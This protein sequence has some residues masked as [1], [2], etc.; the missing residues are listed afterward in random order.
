MRILA[1]KEVESP[2]NF[3]LALP[4]PAVYTFG[5]I[6]HHISG[7]KGQK[8]QTMIY[9]TRP[10]RWTLAITTCLTLGAAVR[11][12]TAL[13]AGKSGEDRIE[14]RMTKDADD[15]LKNNLSDEAKREKLKKE[16]V[17]AMALR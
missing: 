7:P 16:I 15:H 5:G 6:R 3:K 2:R 4:G 1:L 13:A 10:I 11:T 9:R 14:N 12:H 17:R 8:E